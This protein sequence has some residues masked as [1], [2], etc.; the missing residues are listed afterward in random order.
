MTFVSR[1]SRQGREKLLLSRWSCRT[2]RALEL[3]P[4]GVDGGVAEHCC[5]AAHL[6]LL[7]LHSFWHHVVVLPSTAARLSLFCICPEQ[8][9]RCLW[10][11]PTHCCCLGSHVPW[12][13]H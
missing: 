8:Q 10:F 1:D 3:V 12:P 13:V 5:L 2:V 4:A 9:Y 7:G 11:C 6:L